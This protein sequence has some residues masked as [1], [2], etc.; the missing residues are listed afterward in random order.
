MN[1]L[2]QTEINIIINEI[3]NNS[4]YLTNKLLSTIELINN[5]IFYCHIKV[6]VKPYNFY[7]MHHSPHLNN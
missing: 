7:H 1:V 4:N 2:G 6:F 3:G 5:K